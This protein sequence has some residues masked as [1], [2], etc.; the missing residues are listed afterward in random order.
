METAHGSHPTQDADDDG[1][2]VGSWHAVLQGG[3]KVP[4]RRGSMYSYV[5]YVGLKV[6]SMWIRSAT[7]TLPCPRTTRLSA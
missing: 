6:P 1:A 7:W 4:Y 5:I 2:M 3:W